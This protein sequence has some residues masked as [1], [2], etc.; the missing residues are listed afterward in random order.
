MRKIRMTPV[1]LLVL[2]FLAII[3]AGTCLLLLPVSTR[4]GES[5]AFM[6]ALFTAV[7]STCVTGLVTQD[8]YSHWSTFGHVV[9]LVLIQTG[10]IGFMTV[11]FALWKLGG[12]KISLKER[13][14]MQES[15]A[16]PNLS[17]M[18]KLT[19]TILL[20]TFLF[21]GLGAFVMCFRFVPDFG[22]GR[23]I[24][25]SVFTA[26][27]A[28]CNAGID[29]M[30]IKG[31]PFASMTSYSGDPVI[32]LTIPILILVGGLGFFVWQDI[33]NNRFRLRKF[34]LHTKLVLVT[35]AVLVVVPWAIMIVAENNLPWQER[36][37]STF[38]TAVTP[39]TAGFNVLPL[40]GAGSVRQVT[41]FLSIVLMF[42]GGS[43]G[44][45]A[46]G[47]KTNTLAAL[48]L[49][50]VSLL[51]GK[52]S[53]EC[54]GRRLDEEN[55]KNAA[56]FVTLYLLFAM[57][58]VILICIFEQENAHVDSLTAVVFEVISALSTVGLTLGITPFLSVG[59][60]L[61]LSVL[62]YLGRVGCMTF[63]LSLR[64]PSAPAASLP[65]ERIRIG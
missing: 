13:A 41:I 9:I 27:S 2:G 29:L 18:V 21:E 57:L 45:T 3:A 23:G 63:M 15:V 48:V 54:F 30:G 40:S 36:I 17:G 43:S 65:L 5:P 4:S 22:W 59:S 11:V 56:Q 50:V 51:R 39:R 55:V 12:K 1:R 34:S 20:G 32:C 16:A 37:L 49:S 6:D 35:T 19:G 38:F 42:I 60:E 53:V 14:F 52:R 8:T 33:K 61:V 44:S 64:T 24:W 31:E 28:F 25:M 7:T 26:V 10:G 62:M 47:I 58:G 46:G